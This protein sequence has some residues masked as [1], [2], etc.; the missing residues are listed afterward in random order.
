M[1][2]RSYA[3]GDSPLNLQADLAAEF[4]LYLFLTDDRKTL[5]YGKDLS[6]LLLQAGGKDRL[7]LSSEAL[8]FLLQNGVVPPP[9][10]VFAN[11]FVL[12]VGDN[13][14][15]SAPNGRIEIAFGH[16]YPFKNANRPSELGN[17][18]NPNE[19]L[20]MLAD[21]VI[22]RVKTSQPNFLFHSAGKDSNMIALA[23]AEAGWQD[24]VTLITHKSK[25]KAD[26]SGI[27]KSIAKKL[28]FRHRTLFETDDLSTQSR[29]AITDYLASTPFPC[30]DNVTLA[31]P[32]YALQMPELVGANLIDGGGNDVYM[33]VPATRRD[34]LAIGLS[35]ITSKARVL[36]KFTKTENGFAP[37]LRTPVEWMGLA[38]LSLKDSKLLFPR[39]ICTYS[40][41]SH[42]SE[43][44][45]DGD[46]CDF[47]TDI[48][49][50]IV[51]SERH[52]RKVRNFSESVSANLVLP[53]AN[54]KIASYFSKVPEESLF[55]RRKAKNKIVL[56]TILK[57][58]L[59]LDSDAIGKMGFSY[60]ANSV[61]RRNW[62]W[63]KSEILS[64][65][66]WD[67]HGASTLIGRLA[68]EAEKPSGRASALATEALHR[69]FAVSLWSNANPRNSIASGSFGKFGNKGT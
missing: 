24:K 37:F 14:R 65:N 6:G 34:L 7:C 16:T 55:D 56:R 2:T 61:V 38:G 25:G 31:Y 59:A 18:L 51:A 13:A 28:G 44:T 19:I 58:R 45:Y 8:S 46:A 40:H 12:G 41:W 69:I 11:V 64:C 10:T 60:D 62:D 54:E 33:G 27:S 47:K 63:V 30:V 23:L 48:I 5:L 9:L 29:E 43:I 21:A 32:L 68:K 49:A 22:S 57:D 35:R 66:L 26:E 1:N 4:P 20:S 15:I 50:C 36:R 42:K 53:W 52:I 3:A 17:N 67:K 39:T